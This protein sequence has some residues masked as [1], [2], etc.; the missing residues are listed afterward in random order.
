MARWCAST[1]RARGFRSAAACRRGAARTR[2]RRRRCTCVRLP[3]A[4]RSHCPTR[5]SPPPPWKS[6]RGTAASYLRYCAASR[7]LPSTSATSLR[8]PRCARRSRAPPR[9]GAET[10]E[11]GAA[12]AA[13]QRADAQP[14]AAPGLARA[15]TGVVLRLLGVGC[16]IKY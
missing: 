7:A 11:R 10:E 2:T 13:V 8:T 1:R 16:N 6:S 5:C 3:L 15:N 14:L 12:A 9:S 4:T